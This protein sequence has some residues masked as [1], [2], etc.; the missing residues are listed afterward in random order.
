MT[1]YK[2]INCYRPP[3]KLFNKKIILVVKSENLMGRVSQYKR[4]PEF[5]EPIVSEDVG[6]LVD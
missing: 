6:C 2:T 3:S 5:L 4:I 1:V